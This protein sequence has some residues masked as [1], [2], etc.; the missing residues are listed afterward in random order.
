MIQDGGKSIARRQPQKV[1]LSGYHLYMDRLRSGGN[2]VFVC[3]CGVT[4]RVEKEMPLLMK[5]LPPCEKYMVVM[6][7]EDLP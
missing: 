6:D 2:L 3:S 1:K 4:A 5:C 7:K